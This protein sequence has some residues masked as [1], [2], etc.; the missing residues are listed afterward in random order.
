ML[1]LKAPLLP[2]AVE[3]INPGCIVLD[4]CTIR[5]SEAFILGARIRI[6]KSASLLPYLKEFRMDE[7]ATAFGFPA[8]ILLLLAH[9]LAEMIMTLWE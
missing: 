2:F 1:Q 6:S 9:L 5:F 8:S 7:M 3:E 4:S